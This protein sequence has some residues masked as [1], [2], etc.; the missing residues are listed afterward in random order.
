MKICLVGVEFNA[1]KRKYRNT[2][3][4]AKLV[5]AFAILLTRLEIGY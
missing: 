1:D 3:D 4:K 5:L 2:T